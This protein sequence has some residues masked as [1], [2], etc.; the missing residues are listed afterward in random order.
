MFDRMKVT[1]DGVMLTIERRDF[2]A[3][4]SREREGD[5]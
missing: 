1:T 2:E 3:K 4:K 5:Y